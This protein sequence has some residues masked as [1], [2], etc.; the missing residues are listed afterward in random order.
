MSPQDGLLRGGALLDL[1]VRNE[2][3]L[4]GDVQVNGSPSCSD[5]GIIVF[6]TCKTLWEVKKGMGPRVT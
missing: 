3:E 6:K 1:L 4:A 2:K 5:L